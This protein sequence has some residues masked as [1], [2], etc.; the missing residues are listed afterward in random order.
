MRDH[1]LNQWHQ[2]AEASF[3]PYG[4][5]IQIVESYGK[6]EIEYAAIRKSAALMDAAH[7][8]VIEL[9]GKDRLKFLQNL[10]TNDVKPLD[11]GAGC[12]AYLLNVKGRIIADMNI[13]QRDQSA[14]LEVDTRLAPELV[15]ILENYLFSDDVRI[16]DRSNDLSRLTL[17]GPGSTTILETLAERKLEGLNAPL[18]NTDAEILGAKTMVFRNDLCDQM[19]LELVIPADHLVDIWETIIRT[20][21][22]EPEEEHRPQ[23]LY[24]IGWSAFN[25]ARI[26]SGTPLLGIDI[27]DQNLP[28]ET[29]HWYT[30]AVHISK[31]CYL[32]QEVVARMHAHNSVAKMLVGLKI[33]GDAPPL[34]GADLRDSTA[35]VGIV[36]SSCTSPM[37][38][39]T[40]IAM[41]YLKRAF[42]EAGRQV[43][44]YTIRGQVKATVVGLPFWKPTH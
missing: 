28:M 23:K 8:S 20:A 4:P 25:I 32:G 34:A 11:A 21:N 29:A 1:P 43:D 33:A 30:R 22:P 13:L 37:L 15:R 31:G 10:I 27:T 7:R 18:K 24:P 14:Y 17:I 9:T 39:N 2:R 26:E 16:T 5:S 42:A 35:Q 3:L 19:Q 44:V 40:P 38:G 12:Y 41:G 6:P 36:T